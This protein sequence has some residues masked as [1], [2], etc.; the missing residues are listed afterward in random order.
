ME[1]RSNIVV[2]HSKLITSKEGWFECFN[3]PVRV[4]EGGLGLEEEEDTL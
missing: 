3:I 1:L 4:L 2:P